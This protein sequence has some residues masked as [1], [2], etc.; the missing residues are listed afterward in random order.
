[1]YSSKIWAIQYTY[2]VT[3]EFK[4]SSFFFNLNNFD[5]V[6]YSCSVCVKLNCST[7]RAISNL[8]KLFGRKLFFNDNRIE[9]CNSHFQ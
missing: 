4:F 1:M 9:V 3:Y 8:E 2:I 7:E 5:F 6:I